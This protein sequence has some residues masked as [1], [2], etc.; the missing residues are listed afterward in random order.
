MVLFFHFLQL[1]QCTKKTSVYFRSNGGDK[2]RN[3]FPD[4]NGH[5]FENATYIVERKG[6]DADNAINHRSSKN[7]GSCNVNL[8]EVTLK[9]MPLFYSTKSNSYL[10]P[11]TDE[12]FRHMGTT[13]GRT[14]KQKIKKLRENTP[15]LCG[16]SI[17]RCLPNTCNNVNK[18][19]LHVVHFL[20]TFLYTFGR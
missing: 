6:V 8:N 9:W 12:T 2:K 15:C 1:G 17:F 3:S 4:N 10:L 14:I 7:L 19:H 13:D 18:F 16:L 20:R 5:T 11:M